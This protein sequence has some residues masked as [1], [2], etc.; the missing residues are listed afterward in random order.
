M[1]HSRF[2]RFIPVSLTALFA[3]PLLASAQ[4]TDK[5]TGLEAAGAKTGLTTACTG[6]AQVCLV[7]LIGNIISTVLGL[8][9]VFLLVMLLYAGITWM[10]AGGEE[11]KVKQARDTITNAVAGIIIVALSYAISSFVIST[12]STALTGG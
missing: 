5:S 11:K 6:G 10:T 7:T 12:L 3:A 2:S 4:V 1:N 8:V 9:G